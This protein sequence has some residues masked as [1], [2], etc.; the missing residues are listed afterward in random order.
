MFP[1]CLFHFRGRE[2]QCK[3]ILST[4]CLQEALQCHLLPSESHP[5]SAPSPLETFISMRLCDPTCNLYNCVSWWSRSCNFIAGCFNNVNLMPINRKWI[6]FYH[7]NKKRNKSTYTCQIVLLHVNVND[8]RLTVSSNRGS[9]CQTA[10]FSG[11]SCKRSCL[12]RSQISITTV[13]FW[14]TETGGV[15]GNR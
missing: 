10:P 2:N 14:M 7:V 1:L 5:Y 4:P 6:Y 11:R 9:S 8:V 12:G 13:S 3:C 15:T